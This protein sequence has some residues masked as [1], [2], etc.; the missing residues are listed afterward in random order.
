MTVDP[1]ITQAV[2][3]LNA[4]VADQSP[5]APP[6]VVTP[7]VTPPVAPPPVTPPVVVTPPVM[8]THDGDFV[9]NIPGMVVPRLKI[10]GRLIIAAPNVDA[11]AG[12]ECHGV[13]VTNPGWGVGLIQ[14]DAANVAGAKIGP[15]LLNPDTPQPWLN[16][17]RGWGFTCVDVV[18]VRN[19]VDGFDIYN[20]HGPAVN[21]WVNGDVD[22]HA[23]F[24]DS[25]Q[26][27]GITHSDGLQWVGGVGLTIRGRF[28]G[29]LNAA[30]EAVAKRKQANS[31][32]MM[33]QNIG[34]I[35]GLDASGEFCGGNVATV[36]LSSHGGPTSMH[37]GAIAG[38]FDGGSV[39]GFD[40]IRSP[41][42]VCTV[43]GT[44]TDGKPLVDNQHGA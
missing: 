14:C 9:A 5:V 2:A 39:R 35:A 12:G 41:S 1:R 7:P 4:Y 43:T 28:N 42:T 27:D 10:A 25:S 36:N 20:Q 18:T 29:Y 23:C 6:P 11:S 34:I 21:A 3:L 19:C 24:P 40:V 8:Q 38:V 37:V 31:A 17:V 15:W 30:G 13:G 44:R 33:E 22:Q 26:P 16:G 32:L